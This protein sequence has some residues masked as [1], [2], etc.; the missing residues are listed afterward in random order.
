MIHK[1]NLRPVLWCRSRKES[2]GEAGAAARNGLY[3]SGSGSDIH[4]EIQNQ[5]GMK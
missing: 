4:I 2:F 3:Y 5:L 1:K